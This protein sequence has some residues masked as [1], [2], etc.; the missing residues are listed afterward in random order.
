MSQKFVVEYW[1]SLL[2][3]IGEPDAG[4]DWCG[5]AG[6]W[7]GE[8]GESEPGGINDGPTVFVVWPNG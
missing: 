1:C 5:A 3:G 6:W 8:A 4:D 2:E 7:Y